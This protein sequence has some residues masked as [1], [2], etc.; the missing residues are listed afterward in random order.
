[1]KCLA[2]SCALTLAAAPAFAQSAAP[3]SQPPAKIDLAMAIRNSHNNIKGN[4]SKS[5]EKMTEA[6]YGFKPS[7]AAAEVRT[8][9]QIIGHVADA[10]YA[11]CSRAKG[12]PN[13]KTP[14]QF[15]KTPGRADLIKALNDS[16][17][18]CDTVYSSLTDAQALEYITVPGPNNTQRQ[19][20][21]AAPLMNNNVHNNE[22]YGN[23]VTYMRAKGIVPPSSE[24]R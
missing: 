9:G 8:F 15:E 2:F 7:G 12:E 19:I 24:G 20:V 5:A 16:L 3:P 13:S 1:M 4:L 21:R 23:L 17:A 10:N 22:H 14:Q 6:D 11:L 18:Y